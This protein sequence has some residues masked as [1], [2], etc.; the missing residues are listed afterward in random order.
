VVEATGE[1]PVETDATCQVHVVPT[2]SRNY[3]CRVRV[4]CGGHIL[5]G[6][7]SQGYSRC[8]IQENV[9]V[10]ASDESPTEADG[11][12]ILDLDLVHGTA[13]ISDRNPEYSVRLAL[14]P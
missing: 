1:A 5:Y 12:S 3:P 11:D 9:P 4:E 6:G 2:F 8:D 10:D 13:V 7:F 14:E